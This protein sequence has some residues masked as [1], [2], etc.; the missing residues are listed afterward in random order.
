MLVTVVVNVIARLLI[1]QMGRSTRSRY[2][3][4]LS[5]LLFRSPSM[6]GKPLRAIGAGGNGNG[7]S[8]HSQ[9]GH[10]NRSA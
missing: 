10:Q 7:P 2:R 9:R 6:N 5:R 1:S 3:P 4:L 8:G